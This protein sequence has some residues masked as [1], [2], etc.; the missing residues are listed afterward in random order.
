M[1][2]PKSAW[3]AYIGPNNPNK[4]YNE[5]IYKSALEQASWLT[6]IKT[7]ALWSA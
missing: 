4:P 6:S 3:L 5:K 7:T 2:D 1:D